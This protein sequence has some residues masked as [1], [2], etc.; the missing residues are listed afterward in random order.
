MFDYN[1]L[2]LISL[3]KNVIFVLRVSQFHQSVALLPGN[4][5]CQF[6][7]ADYLLEEIIRRNN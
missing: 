6:M 1:D 5:I 2:I 3:F 7:F 4:E